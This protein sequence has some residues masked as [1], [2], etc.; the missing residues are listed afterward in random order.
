MKRL[1]LIRSAVLVSSGALLF[2]AAGCTPLPI[3]DILQTA[4]LAVTAAGS[5]A[6]LEN[7]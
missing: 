3:L 6:I 7:I 2:Q 1:R 4:L 5:I